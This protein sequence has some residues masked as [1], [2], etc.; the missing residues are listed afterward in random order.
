M[1][2]AMTFEN[3]RC[4]S[5]QRLVQEVFADPI[6]P[7]QAA[8]VEMFGRNIDQASQFPGVPVDG[9]RLQR[10]IE[11]RIVQPAEDQGY[12]G[13]VPDFG[14][15]ARLPEESQ[16]FQKVFRHRA[17]LV[18]GHLAIRAEF[19]ACRQ[20][21]SGMRVRHA[22]PARQSSSVT[23]S[24]LWRENDT[25]SQKCLNLFSAFSR[26]YSGFFPLAPRLLT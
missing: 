19:E 25:A 23:I 11:C 1:T 7:A 4:L 15:G 8:G 2:H 6:G 9:P 26:S 5:A 3:A 17:H 14:V 13:Q 22:S 16:G 10:R 18:L 12:A 21:E 20:C 24:T